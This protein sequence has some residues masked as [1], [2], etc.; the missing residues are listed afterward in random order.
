MPVPPAS[1]LSGK[2]RATLKSL[3]AGTPLALRASGEVP[4]PDV[5]EYR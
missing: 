2:H 4:T 1:R 3:T 5:E